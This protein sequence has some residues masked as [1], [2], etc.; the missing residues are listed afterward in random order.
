M[1][2]PRLV[3]SK[4]TLI[5][6]RE[7]GLT[8]EQMAE[9]VFEQ[10]GHRISRNAISAAFQR[11]GLSNPGK[12]YREALPWVVS[13]G[14]AKSMQARMLRFMGRLSQGGELS[15]HEQGQ[16][17]RWLAEIMAQHL[18]VAYDPDDDLGFHYIDARFKDHD[19]DI[20]IRRKPIHIDLGSGSTGGGL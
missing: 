17:D 19:S 12:R 1:A 10:G 6:W 20:P 11:Y 15:A 9:R 5:H 3:P 2:P 16:Y 18:I 8:H 4:D 13:A 14:H 7:E